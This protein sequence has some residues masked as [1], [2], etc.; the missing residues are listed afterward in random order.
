MSRSLSPF[1]R[2]LT[3]RLMQVRRNLADYQSIRFAAKRAEI[4]SG[5][6]LHSAIH[7]M[8]RPHSERSAAT[9]SSCEAR[10]AGSRQAS[11]ATANSESETSAKT[12][13]S[14]GRVP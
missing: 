3:F 14:S 7:S 5:F 2:Q 11:A 8:L 6:P 13:G 4:G 10:Q 9:G 1:A 12:S